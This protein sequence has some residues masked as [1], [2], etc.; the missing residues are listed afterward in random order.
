MA[1]SGLKFADILI[2]WP[3][4][5]QWLRDLMKSR[6]IFFSC[7]LLLFRESER[8]VG[9]QYD[10]CNIMQ[11]WS[12]VSP[13]KNDTP[14]VVLW[15]QL[16]SWPRSGYHWISVVVS[17]VSSKFNGLG[18]QGKS[19]GDHG[20]F[21]VFSHYNLQ[22]SCPFSDVPFQVADSTLLWMTIRCLGNSK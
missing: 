14:L 6:L 20:F 18:N 13:V 9:L 2:C 4:I 19:T 11:L 16:I 3:K 8:R 17:A 1:V 12:M 15:Y 5:H 21:H 22:W 7:S 10:K